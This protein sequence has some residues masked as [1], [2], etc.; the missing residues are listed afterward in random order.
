VGGFRLE[1]WGQAR[2]SEGGIFRS[3]IEDR[4]R[5]RC[6]KWGGESCYTGDILH[7][8][9]TGVGGRD[10]SLII[11]TLVLTYVGEGDDSY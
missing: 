2:G 6:G 5:G 4:L 3:E 1:Y 7:N 9:H 10:I 11:Y 8:F